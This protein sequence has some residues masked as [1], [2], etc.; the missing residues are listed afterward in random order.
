VEDDATD[1]ARGAV[2]DEAERVRAERRFR[3]GAQQP[4]ALAVEHRYRDD[5]AGVLLHPVADGERI[6]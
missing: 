5:A 3:A 1:A 6:S 2:V 4:V